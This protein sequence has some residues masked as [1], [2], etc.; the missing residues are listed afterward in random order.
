MSEVNL[1]DAVKKQVEYYFSKENL[2]S[3]PYLTS[4]MDAQMCVPINVVMKV[5]IAFAWLLS[6]ISP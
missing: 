3:D 6:Y 2:L 1:I 5:N 4:Q